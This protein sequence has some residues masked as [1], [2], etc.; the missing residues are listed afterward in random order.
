M[1]IGFLIWADEQVISLKWLPLQPTAR[2][3]LFINYESRGE[4]LIAHDD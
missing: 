1:A 3:S 2:I 4:A